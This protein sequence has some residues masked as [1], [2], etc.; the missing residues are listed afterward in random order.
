M[1]TN[2][3]IFGLRFSSN[4][5]FSL[6]THSRTKKKNTQFLGILPVWT[7]RCSLVITLYLH[8]HQ[9]L[10]LRREV[11]DHWTCIASNDV[12]VSLIPLVFLM[13]VSQ[14]KLSYMIAGNNFTWPTEPFFFK[15]GDTTCILL[16]WSQEL[17]K[18]LTVSGGLVHHSQLQNILHPACMM[19]VI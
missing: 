15:L 13:Q 5:I 4:F 14:G 6:Q 16:G 9:Y 1:D 12:A 10:L 17:G 18:E 7:R 8:I 11:E 3:F 19:L 2:G